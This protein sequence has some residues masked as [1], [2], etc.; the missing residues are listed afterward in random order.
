M[1]LPVVLLAVFFLLL[2]ASPACTVNQLVGDLALVT[3]G[4]DEAEDGG[5]DADDDGG[6]ENED[7]GPRDGGP[8]DGGDTFQ[9]FPLRAQ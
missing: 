4:G 1:R 6:V 9:A 3:D 7:G 2:G 5:P 8:R